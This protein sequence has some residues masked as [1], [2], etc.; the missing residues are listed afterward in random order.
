MLENTGGPIK[1]ILMSP[2]PCKLHL[3]VEID[4]LRCI[5]YN[6]HELQNLANWHFSPENFKNRS[7]RFHVAVGLNKNV[8]HCISIRKP[9]IMENLK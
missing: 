5:W 9:E 3:P 1:L 4:I 6:V 8:R 2:S 7:G